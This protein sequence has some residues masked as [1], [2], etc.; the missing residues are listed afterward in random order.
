MLQVDH[1]KWGQ[2]IDDLR[3]LAMT[4]E[5]VR[6]R[7]RFLALFEIAEGRSATA[8]AAQSERHDDTVQGWVHRYN[9]G[10]PEALTYRRTGGWR[11]FSRGS[12][13]G[14]ETPCAPRWSSPRR[15][16]P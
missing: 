8:W 14:S 13:R 16:Q 4:A 15:P 11:S 10:G 5:H 6:T 1:E 12:R 7:E 2:T 3:R 9:E